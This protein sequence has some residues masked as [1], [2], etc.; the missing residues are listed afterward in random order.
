MERDDWVTRARLPAVEASPH[1]QLLDVVWVV[2][3][4]VHFVRFEARHCF[5][6]DLNPHL[7]DADRKKQTTC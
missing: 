3:G 7:L 4:G 5:G 2:R 6:I 1:P